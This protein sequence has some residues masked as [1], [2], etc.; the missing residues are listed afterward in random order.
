[1]CLLP[2]QDHVEEKLEGQYYLLLYFCHVGYAEEIK[3]IHLLNIR[4]ARC[5]GSRVAGAAGRRGRRSRS[6]RGGGR[7]RLGRLRR[8]CDRSKRRR[9]GSGGALLRGRGP[10]SPS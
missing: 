6:R 4:C 10:P 5:R 1:M 9:G 7:R 8:R 2:A 3:G